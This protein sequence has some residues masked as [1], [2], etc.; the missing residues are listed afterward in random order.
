LQALPELIGLAAQ[1][2]VGERLDLRLELAG[3][4]HVARVAA[5]EP[6]VAA[7]EDAR[8]E[9]EQGRS[10]NWE[11]TLPDKHLSSA[12][13]S[14]SGVL[15][16]IDAAGAQLVLGPRISRSGAPVRARAGRTRPASRAQRPMK[17]SGSTWRPLCST[18][19]CTCGPVECPV[20]PM[21]AIGSPRLT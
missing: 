19:K 14:G 8:E 2:L 6:L 13:G 10:V 3:G 7:A 18:S 16:A 12:T 20:E 5:N 15:Y 11:N 21:R 1:R 4:A 17:D 9:V